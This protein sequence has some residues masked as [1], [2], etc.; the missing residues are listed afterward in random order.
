VSS[1]QLSLLD[2]TELEKFQNAMAL[3]TVFRLACVCYG[4]LT[5][6]VPTILKNIEP[7]LEHTRLNCFIGLDS[8]I[9]NGPIARRP[10]LID[11]S[12]SQLFPIL[13]IPFLYC[14]LDPLPKIIFRLLVREKLLGGMRN[15][16]QILIQLPT[17]GAFLD[18]GMVFYIRP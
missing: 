12:S 6:W 18:M 8:N 2:N 16:L 3:G 17:N 13:R 10:S 9:L 5:T 14:G 7:R 15:R 11:L 1:Y 4:V